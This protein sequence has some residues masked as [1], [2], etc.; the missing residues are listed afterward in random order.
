MSEK[1]TL[2]ISPVVAA[3]VRPGTPQETRLA[4]CAAA[5]SMIV[6]D[7]L[8]LLFCLSKDAEPAV[9]AAALVAL[10]NVPVEIIEAFIQSPNPHPLM[11]HAL[12]TLCPDY[13][14][15]SSDSECPLLPDDDGSNV[16][17]DESPPE[18]ESESED[19]DQVNE[20]DEQ[21]L[22]KYKMAQ[23]MGIGEK[24]KMALSGDK[25]WRSILVKDANKLVSGSVIKNPRISEAE[26][27]TLI[28][29]G[30]QND[31]I[32]RLICANKEWIKNYKIRKALIESNRTLVQ[33]AVRYL[34][35]MD[36]KDLASFAKS[37]NISSVLST[38]AKRLL[39]NKKR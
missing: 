31:E 36:V 22:S 23:L 28:K 29:A 19:Q 13:P 16:L 24:I 6:T 30:I 11:L 32:M 37:K 3:Y 14:V 18:N 38:M 39:L 35:T 26:I 9:K 10:K 33:N 17:P 8:M 20:E 34:G 12:R 15:S 7:R 4:G 27:L 5:V 2:T 25:E 1:V 21:F